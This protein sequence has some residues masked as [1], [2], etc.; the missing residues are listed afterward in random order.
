V[1]TQH[2]RLGLFQHDLLH[3]G[4]HGFCGNGEA[5]VCAMVNRHEVA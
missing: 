1:I 5:Y 4:C 3:P 2:E